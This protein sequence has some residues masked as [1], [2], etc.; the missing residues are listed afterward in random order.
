MRPE[1]AGDPSQISSFS[2]ES[3]ILKD[4]SLAGAS[5]DSCVPLNLEYTNCGHSD[6]GMRAARSAS[7]GTPAR[8]ASNAFA[9]DERRFCLRLATSVGVA[10]LLAPHERRNTMKTLGLIGGMSWQSTALYYRWINEGVNR[11]LGPG[12]SAKI[13]LWSV[14]FSEISRLQAAGEWEAAGRLLADCGRRL[15]AA[16][17]DALLICTNTMHQ[18]ADAVSAATSVP[19]IH[20]ADATADHI[21]E[22]GYPRVA[23]LGT[24]FTMERD[25]YRNRLTARGITVMTPDQAERD[26][27][28]R[29]IYQELCE[30]VIRDESRARYV[31]IIERLA[32][33]GAQAVI[34]GCTEIT[35]LIGDEDSPIPTVDTTRIHADSAVRFALG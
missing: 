32:S 33:D 24:R 5:R 8:T 1:S 7:R 21:L 10:M 20:L 19:L 23:L 13:V 6:Q 11:A 35:L 22:N 4:A 2:S 29:I 17:A 26:D 16:G 31:E 18:V 3:G 34:L 27:I 28:H 25:F 30:G 14:D 15:E 12:H 9:N